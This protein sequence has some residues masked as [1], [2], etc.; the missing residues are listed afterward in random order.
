MKMAAKGDLAKQILTLLGGSDNIESVT[1]CA[2]R[3]RPILKDHTVADVKQLEELPEVAGVVNQENG[4]QIVIGTNV[5]DVYD[6]F[7]KLL[8]VDANESENDVK[9]VNMKGDKKE[10]HLLNDFITLVVSIFSPLLPIL[11]G[12]GLL[13]GFTILA[14][15]LGWLSEKSTTNLI[16]TVSATAVFYFLPLLVALT[17]AKKFNTSPYVAMVVMGALIMPDFINLVKGDGG[18]TISMYGLSVPVF[19][20]TSQVLP[21]IIMTWLQSKMEHFMK[22]KLPSSLH[23]VVIPT[24]LLV[25]LVPVFA[26]IVGP[27][28]N[29][30]SIGIANVVDMLANINQVVTG[31][32]IGGIW[33]ILIL[34]GVHWAPNTMVIIPEI[35]AKGYSPFIAYGANANFGMA[36]AALAIFLRSKNKGLKSFSMSAI[37]SVMLS[38]IVEPAIYGLG[39]KFKTPLVAGCLGAAM[40]GAFMGLFRVVGNAFV[41]GGLTTIPAFAGPTLWAYVVGLMISFAGGMVLTLMMGIKDPAAEMK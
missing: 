33:N 34:F 32:I 35:A 1:Y 38:G 10:K 3:L 13:R 24:V 22:R 17:S 27:L 21:A 36:G 40:G 12:S 15:Q 41:F 39:I 20:Y 26:G 25:V 14:N 18:N 16:L 4:V 11:A 30:L 19:K 9:A 5:G 8:P 28:G 6:D 31:A 2:T 29:Y 23:L 7:V 37:I